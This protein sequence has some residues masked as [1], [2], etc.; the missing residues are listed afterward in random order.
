MAALKSTRTVGCGPRGRSL[1]PLVLRLSPRPPTVARMRSSGI[2]AA[3][4]S[5]RAALARG[6]RPRARAACAGPPAPRAGTRAGPAASSARAARPRARPA[7]REVASGR[8]RKICSEQPGS[9]RAGPCGP[10]A[11]GSSARPARPRSPT[12]RGGGRPAPPPTPRRGPGSSPPAGRAARRRRSLPAGT[13]PPAPGRLRGPA[14]AALL[15]RA[16]S[17]QERA[18]G[19]HRLAR[20][21]GHCASSARGQVGAG[22][23]GLP[24]ERV[25]ASPARCLG[26]AAAGRSGDWKP[27]VVLAW[28]AQEPSPSSSRR[29]SP[30]AWHTA[31]RPWPR[32]PGPARTSCSSLWARAPLAVVVSMTGRTVAC[33]MSA[34][35]R[36]TTPSPRRSGP[37]IGGSSSSGVPR[38]GAPLGRPRRPALA[39]RDDV[40][41]VGPPPSPKPLGRRLHAR[42]AEVQPLG[43]PSIREAEAHRAEIEHPGP[44]WRRSAPPAPCRSGRRAGAASRAA[45]PLGVLRAIPAVAGDPKRRRRAG[46][47]PRRAGRAGRDRALGISRR[48]S[49]RRG[50]PGAAWSGPTV[51]GRPPR[52]ACRARPSTAGV[53]RNPADRFRM[54]PS[55]RGGGVW[56]RWR[57]WLPGHGGAGPALPG[58]AGIEFSAAT[59]R[60]S[61]SSPRGAAAA[62]WPGSWASAGSGRPRSCAATTRAVR[63]A[64]G[65]GGAGTPARGR[66]WAPR[67]RRRCGPRWASRPPTAGCGPGPRWRRGWRARL[68]REVWPQRASDHLRKLG[69]SPQ[70]PRPRHA[71]VASPE[72]QADN[73]K[74]LR[75]GA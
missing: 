21:L 60:W 42:D 58:G 9:C 31:S 43:D 32:S 12:A 59:S 64:W 73:K 69:H 13:R 44:W 24:P 37:R 30:R 75:A 68:G 54:A 70:V 22:G 49:A 17:R 41:L 51:R 62:R 1:Q 34:S 18:V 7:H 55:G 16:D 47:G 10:R 57:W 52:L 35:T 56:R 38:P 15:A 25:A 61:G 29:N 46:G 63:R 19:Q 67:T 26:A 6:G 50:S 45:T 48:R 39:P 5:R 71:K 23:D 53:I 40:D 4:A 65:T 3:T 66:S 28:T 27:S 74:A 11:G 14:P 72:A 36:T 20:Q 2:S 33:R 8:P